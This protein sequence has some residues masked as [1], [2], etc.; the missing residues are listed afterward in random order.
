MDRGAW[1]ATV[2][3]VVKSWTQLK[4]LNMHAASITSKVCPSHLPVT[5]KVN[6]RINEK[7]L[8]SKKCYYVP[9][10]QNLSREKQT[11][12]RK[13]WKFSWGLEARR[14]SEF[15]E[16]EQVERKVGSELTG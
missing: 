10:G 11:M 8:Y 14:R 2:H 13:E 15:L 9:Q 16:A 12:E 3:R 7:I 5:E 4:R 1:W 6:E